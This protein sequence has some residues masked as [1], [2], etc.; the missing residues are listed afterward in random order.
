MPK[1]QQG[2]EQL[3]REDFSSLVFKQKIY[4]SVKVPEAIAL[5]EKLSNIAGK[6]AKATKD[7]SAFVKEIVKRLKD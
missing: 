6:S 3:F 7:M 2:Y 4:Q 5:Q 1:S